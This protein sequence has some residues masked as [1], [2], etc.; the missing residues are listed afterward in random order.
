VADRILI[1][2]DNERLSAILAEELREDG[3]EVA[4]AG[5]G[6]AGVDALRDGGFDLVVLDIRM[7]VMDGLDALGKILAR[8]RRI[9]VVIHTAYGTYKEDFR[10]WSADAYVTKSSDSGPLMETIRRLLTTRRTAGEEGE[11]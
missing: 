4:I 8:D 3:Y 11:G 7:P 9:P 6:R 2:D 5:N 10:A 1:I